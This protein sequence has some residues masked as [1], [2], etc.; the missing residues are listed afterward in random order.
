MDYRQ[1]GSTSISNSRK[2]LLAVYQVPSPNMATMES[3][4]SHP[5]NALQAKA[6]TSPASLSFPGGT[7][8]LTPPTEERNN[9]N[10]PGPSGYTQEGPATAGTVVTPATPAATPGAG[11]GV[12]GIVP[13]LQ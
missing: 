11:A 3:L 5:Q 2:F 8:D 10:K 7:G 12:S 6:F 13:T 4:R 9:I 1:S